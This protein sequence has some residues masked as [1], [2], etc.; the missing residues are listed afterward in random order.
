MKTRTLRRLLGLALLILPAIQSPANEDRLLGKIDFPNSGAE[1]A[2][3]SFIE[4]VLYLHNFEYQEAAAA[5][6]TARGIDP[7]FALA[8]WGE[9]MTYNHPLWNRQAR[10]EAREILLELGRT[11]EDR[12]AKAPTPREK[13]YLAAVEI[14]FGT[15]PETASLSTRE[16]DLQYRDAM[17]RLQETYPDDHEATVL[18][19]LS[20]LGTGV[21]NRDDSTYM[22]AAA[23]LTK[24]WDA[25]REHPGAAHY[26]IHCYDD[27]V[28]APLGLPM[29]RAY[30]RI[31]PAAAHAQHMT[32][33]IFVALGMWDDL[34]EANE[35]AVE[36]EFGPLDST[37]ERPLTASHYVYWLQ[38]G[39]LQ[40]GRIEEARQLM[41]AAR[42][43]IEDHPM[44]REMTY[45]GTMVARY[46]LDTGD[47]KSVDR[48]RAPEGVS[49]PTPNYYFALAVAAIKNG[50]LETATSLGEYIRVHDGGHPE[51]SP[52]AAATAVLR[53]ELDALIAL[54]RD[55]P[56]LAIAL[57]N[58]AVEMENALPFKYG[59]PHIVKPPAELL[60]EILLEL[61]NA[62]EAQQAYEDQ[63]ERTPRRTSSLT[64]LGRAARKNGDSTAA[65][66]AFGQLTNI[67]SGA[68]SDFAGP[69]LAALESHAD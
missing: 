53:K 14:L 33:H 30:S 63:L 15:S 52:D 39:Y 69:V 12:A 8:Y 16:R 65:T 7:D 29:A 36:I 60:G 32:S 28:H 23:V 58:E 44:G 4:G 51:A 54:A 41:A 5:F 26:L 56:D 21:Q 27:P 11:P 50:D 22:R 64:G 9:A 3:D 48:W 57:A 49:I 62:P 1:A 31:A 13:D 61:G 6:R 24:V 10:A 19:G 43:R 25:N 55:E 66:E 20:I 47:W 18:Y 2:Q 42:D 67:W 37:E 46:L 45:Y 35:K 59:P 17:R 38:Y 68:D 34:V 40:Q